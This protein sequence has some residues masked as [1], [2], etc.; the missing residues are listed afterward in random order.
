MKKILARIKDKAILI[1]NIQG[2]VSTWHYI[3]PYIISKDIEFQN[4]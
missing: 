2:F 1:K 4:N 3:L